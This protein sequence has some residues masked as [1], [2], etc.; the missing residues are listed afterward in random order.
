MVG[1]DAG[2]EQALASLHPEVVVPIEL[3]NCNCQYPEYW[4]QLARS[5]QVDAVVLGT[6]TSERGIKIELACLRAACDLKLPVIVIEDMP[7]NYQPDQYLVPDLIVVESALVG[8]YVRQRAY[9]LYPAPIISGAS[10]RYDSLRLQAKQ[11]RR[12][13]FK[14]SSHRLVWLGQPETQANLISLERLLPHLSRMGLELLFRAHPRDD[15]YHRG[16]YRQLFSSPGNKVLDV[17]GF[18]IAAIFSYQPGLVLTHFSSM[19]I[20]CAFLGTPC[21]NVLFPE[22][23]GK[24][25]TE[26]TGLERPFL[27]EVGGSGTIS[28]VDA[29]EF[30]LEQLLFNESV[31]K[32]QMARFDE[33]FDIATLQHPGVVNAIERVVLAKQKNR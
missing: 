29:I 2:P 7:G 28:D 5:S 16:R 14:N 6:S 32:E 24:I 19:A 21:C 23:G 22:G 15:G 17:S 25:Y 4:T 8:N 26:M 12:L 11:G 18:D 33:Y 31:R 1:V 27:C 20:E 30:E 13:T 10:V 3:T 9:G